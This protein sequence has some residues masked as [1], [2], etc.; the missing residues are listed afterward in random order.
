[1][2]TASAAALS[3]YKNHGKQ[4]VAGEDFAPNKVGPVWIYTALEMKDSDDKT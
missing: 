4:L 3:D 2:S 1:M